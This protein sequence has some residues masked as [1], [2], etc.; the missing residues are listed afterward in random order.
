MGVYLADQTLVFLQSILA[1]A[2]LGVLYD[3][4]RISRVAFT[5]PSGI[6]FVEDIVYFLVCAMTT[7]LFFLS[8][9]E[10]VVRFFLL[11]GETIGWVLY[12]FTLGSVVMKVS[13]VIIA[14]IRA[15]LHFIIHYIFLPI[16]RLIYAIV[17]LVCKPFAFIWGKLKKS[18]QKLRF[19]LKVGRV[20]LYNHCIALLTPRRRKADREGTGNDTQDEEP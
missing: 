10:G 8:V 11:A 5:T 2:L 1:G 4:F 16:W 9:N 18:L 13:K 19:R 3:L 17:R 15:V 20:V 7:F 14:C 12:H 6:I